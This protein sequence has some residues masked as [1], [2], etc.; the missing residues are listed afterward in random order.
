M[1]YF[2]NVCFDYNLIFLIPLFC[3]LTA[4]FNKDLRPEMSAGLLLLLLGYALP[5]GLSVFL[6]EKIFLHFQ[7]AGLCLLGFAQAKY[8]LADKKD[9]VIS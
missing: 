6:G 5:R 2:A 1:V 3:F 4:A 7:A 8:L 9:R